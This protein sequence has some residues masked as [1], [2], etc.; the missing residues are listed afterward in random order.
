MSIVS[1]CSSIRRKLLSPHFSGLV[2]MQLAT[3]NQLE[4]INTC[5]DLSVQRCT[6]FSI[7]VI[8]ADGCAHRKKKG[9]S[10][11]K[12]TSLTLFGTYLI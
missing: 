9:S 1:L 7:S 6:A 4:A 8:V 3:E 5:L 11:T 2:R 10:T 12:K